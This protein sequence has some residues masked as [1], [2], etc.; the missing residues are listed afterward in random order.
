[1]NV[2]IAELLSG[3]A[4]RLCADE[5][6][7]CARTLRHVQGDEIQCIDGKGLGFRAK[8]LAIVKDGV[9]LLVLDR[10]E[11]WGEHSHEIVLAVSPL[12][13]KD[14]FEWLLEK[15]V[16]LG[17]TRIVP[18]LCKN[19]QPDRSKPERLQGIL[20][21]ATKQCKRS[22]IPTLDAPTKFGDFV[23]HNACEQKLLA[24]CEA[25][26]NM[27][28]LGLRAQ[29]PLQSICVVIG[30]EGDFSSEEVAAAQGAGFRVVSL[31][32]TRLRTET[33]GMFALACVK[34]SLEF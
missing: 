27:N 34:Q 19:T 7:H 30:P 21:A 5:A 17:A 33:A 28:R 6:R 4:A 29:N 8:I 25:E 22:R 23:R 3:G 11:N 9:E 10:F 1:M 12:R 26:V 13:L 2:F 15:A 14:R 31:G 16:E 24:W 32:G 20:S 18:L